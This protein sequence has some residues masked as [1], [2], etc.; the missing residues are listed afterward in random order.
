VRTG[1]SFA[2]NWTLHDQRHSA[3]KRMV[4]GPDRDL[5]IHRLTA[6]PRAMCRFGL[7]QWLRA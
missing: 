5:E 6:R 7:D 3:A 2:A 4:R 1:P